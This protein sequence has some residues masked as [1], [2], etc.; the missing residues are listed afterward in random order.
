MAAPAS[1]QAQVVGGTLS[2]S[3]S[4]KSG[5]VVPQAQIVIT[6]TATGVAHNVTTNADGFYTAPDLLPG[7]YEVTISAPGFATLARSGITL[8]VGAKQVLNLTL[9][10]GKTEQQ[11]QVVEEAPTVELASS[12]ISAEVNST[13]VRELS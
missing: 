9:E 6:N 5:A 10:V 12:S 1:L 2:G 11:I 8:T 3:V 13:T 4:D 7:P